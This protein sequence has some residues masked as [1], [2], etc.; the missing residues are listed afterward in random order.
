MFCNC[1]HVLTDSLSARGWAECDGA[2]VNL[3]PSN[4]KYKHTAV[5]EQS[6]QLNT[7]AN[8]DRNSTTM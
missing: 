3:I 4:S 2:R 6:Q 8:N 7:S 5:E 1:A